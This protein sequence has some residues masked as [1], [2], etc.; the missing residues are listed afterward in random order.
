MSVFEEIVDSK[1]VKVFKVLSHNS[2]KYFHLNKLSRVSNVPVST[3]FRI[4]KKMVKIGIV[5]QMNIDKIKL[6]KI[7]DNK[8]TEELRKV[9]EK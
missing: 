6:Y 9:L 3:T 7:A 4:V 1:L 2:D 8:K 5:E